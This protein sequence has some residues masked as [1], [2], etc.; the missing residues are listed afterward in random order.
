[1]MNLALFGVMTLVIMTN[2]PYFKITAF[3]PAFQ[4]LCGS[5]PFSTI[6]WFA[7]YLVLGV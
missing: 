2:D 7:A 1:M 4:K 6:F 5:T 3:K